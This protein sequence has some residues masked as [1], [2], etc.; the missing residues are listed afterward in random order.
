[1]LAGLL[2]ALSTRLQRKFQG[3][4]RVSATLYEKLASKVL[5]RMYDIVVE[6]IDETKRV[7]VDVGCGTGKLMAKTVLQGKSEFMLGLDVSKAMINIAKKN[8]RRNGVYDKCDIILGD[9]H[10]LPFRDRAL[11][12]ILSTGT[13]HHLRKPLTFFGE[14]LRVLKEDCEAWI[15]ELSYDISYHEV[16]ETA[17]IMNKQSLLLKIAST[18]HGIPRRELLKEYIKPFKSKHREY[19]VNLLT[20][21]LISKI[22]LVKK[23]LS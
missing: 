9:A 22:I 2:N 5:E 10:H 6:E 16:R 11:N 13:L 20:Q 4:P 23:T 14:C 15:Y 8:L 19:Y 1:M 18:L 21:G 17:K 7:V 12:L 3:I